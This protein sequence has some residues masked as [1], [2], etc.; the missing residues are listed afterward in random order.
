[1]YTVGQN[2]VHP[3]HGAGTIGQ[4][5]KKT[6]DGC[7]K[8]YYVLS[9]GS[10]DISVTLPVD[11]CG[12]VGLRPVIGRG[13]A[14]RLLSAIPLLKVSDTDGNWNRRYR[15]N[16]QS[17]K[18]GDPLKVATVI[19]GLMQ[20]DNRRGLST[21]ERRMLHYARDILVSEMTVS[22][23]LSEQELENKLTLAVG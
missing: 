4:I 10:G 5:V 7:A 2:V 15:E 6:E 18:S 20:R 22:L 1:M 23:Q 9:F 3:L 17:I 12:D 8:N 11:K 13:E 19:K 16:M 14:E 21:G